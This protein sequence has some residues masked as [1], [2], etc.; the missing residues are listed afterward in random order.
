MDGA[1]YFNG[2]WFLDPAGGPGAS[3]TLPILPA[4]WA[5]EGW[6]VV[7]G[8]PVSTGTFT[9][10]T[11]ADSDMGG[12]AAGA[13]PAPPFPGQDFVSPATDLRGGVAVISVE[14]VPDNS[15]AP[16]TLKPLVDMNIAD[17][18][19]PGVVQMLSLIHI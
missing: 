15:P 12:P 16:F 8:A 2:I 14:P 1:D 3:L 9:S 17:T 7:G 13:N 6:V 4:G 5:Y 11:G 10:V 18:G 19:A